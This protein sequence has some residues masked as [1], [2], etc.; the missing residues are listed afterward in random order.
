MVMPPRT[1]VYIHICAALST[2]KLTFQARLRI[3]ERKEISQKTGLSLGQR[4]AVP[5]DW[6]EPRFLMSIDGGSAGAT[7]L[8]SSRSSLYAHLPELKCRLAPEL[9][10]RP[11]GQK[12]L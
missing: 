9:G 11:V 8:S 12:K 2:A 6:G 1:N 7:R 4:S 10:R 3:A 5:A